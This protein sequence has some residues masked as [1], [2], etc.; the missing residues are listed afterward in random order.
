MESISGKPLT[1]NLSDYSGSPSEVPG[2]V[3]GKM[4]II[5]LGEKVDD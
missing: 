5:I 1:T 4:G 3:D 2:E